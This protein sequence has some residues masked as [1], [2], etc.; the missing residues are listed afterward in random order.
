MLRRIIKVRIR[1]GLKVL[2]V[3]SSV[4]LLFIIVSDRMVSAHVRS[5]YDSIDEIPKNKV[6]LLLGTS[7]HVKNGG[8]NLYYHHRIQAAVKL[9]HS[10]KIE[11]ILISGDN[12][13]VYYDE[14]TTMKKDLIA[15]GV[16]ANKIYLDYAGFRTLDSVVRS[17][18][19]LSKR[20]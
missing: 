8:I 18:E 14:P 4:L 20:P 1:L 12:G 7:K 13:S 6:G 9:Y 19:F 16:P 17:K 15:L 5:C 3:L 10:G 2:T 11:Y